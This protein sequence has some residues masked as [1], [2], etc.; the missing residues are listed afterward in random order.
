MRI[1]QDISRPLDPVEFARAAEIE[2][3]PWQG[4]LLRDQPKRAL[5]CCSRQSGKTTTTAIM[6]LHTACYTPDALIVLVAPAQRQSAEML[7]T[8]RGLHTRIDGL[9]DLLG[10]SVLRIEMA[11]SSRILA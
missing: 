8:I 6:A 10:D 11:N 7:R 5:L 9:P 3:D 2:P 1:E 4:K